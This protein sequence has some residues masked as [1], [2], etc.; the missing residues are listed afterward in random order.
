MQKSNKQFRKNDG[1]YKAMIPV[2]IAGAK[3]FIDPATIDQSK[4]NHYHGQTKDGTQV[5][6]LKM[7]IVGDSLFTT[8]TNNS[9]IS[10]FGANDCEVGFAAHLRSIG[11]EVTAPVQPQ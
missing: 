8:D 1:P 3:G 5:H 10:S 4:W 2:L 11:Y 9:F 6:S 7:Q